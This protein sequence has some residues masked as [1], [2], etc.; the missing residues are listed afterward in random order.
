MDYENLPAY[1]RA[2]ALAMQIFDLTVSFPKNEQYALTD[3]LRRSSRSICTNLAEACSRSFYPKYYVSKLVDCKAQIAETKVWL[4]FARRCG[5]IAETDCEMLAAAFTEIDTLM[6]Y[7]KE[8][9]KVQ[10]QKRKV[11]RR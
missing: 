9:L 3:P 1:R 11:A 7:M 4:E 10:P 5:Y 8:N 6:Y 2:T